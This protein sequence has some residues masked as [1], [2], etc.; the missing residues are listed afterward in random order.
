MRITWGKNNPDQSVTGGGVVSG[1]ERCPV[2]YSQHTL[3]QALL[4]E[5]AVSQDALHNAL[6]IRDESGGFL[7][8]ILVDNSS[9]S[10]DS[11]TAF[12]AKY[13]RVPHLSLLDYLIDDS[14]I[15]LI[16]QEICIKHRILPVDKLGKN[17]TVAMVNPLNKAALEDAQNCV[18][19]L[20]V[21]P[22]LCAHSHFI[23][24][25]ERLF[26]ENDG[27]AK[28]K[29]NEVH[30]EDFGFTPFDAD[31]GDLEDTTSDDILDGEAVVTEIMS[32]FDEEVDDEQTGNEAVATDQVPADQAAA[33]LEST[34]S[35][36][37]SM[38][39]AMRESMRGTY[40]L[41]AR[42]L[43]LFNGLSPEAVAKVFASGMTVELEPGQ[44]L[45]AKGEEGRELY[46]VLRGAIE[47]RDGDNLIV[48]VPS[49]EIVGE[50][51]WVSDAPRN[52][53][54]IAKQTTSLIT[55]TDD[56]FKN[57]LTK[58]NAVQLLMNII[59]ILTQRIRTDRGE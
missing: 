39:S 30:M 10:E 13:C 16:P 52:D 59:L 19:D 18:P 15:N 37:D 1:G 49:G 28:P 31:D 36:V 40:T 45:Y 12:L 22:V 5:G 41:L 56:I 25:A 7:G 53:T 43:E 26:G 58:E 38:L 6:E 55:L 42:R 23:A 44:V 3:A 11:L 2:D 32:S 20:R 48:T 29:S 46:V 21:R 47:L 35:E 57:L 8:Q 33:E 51:A 24:I 14:L 50:A 4:N 27:I 17:L 54:A 9:I 34:V